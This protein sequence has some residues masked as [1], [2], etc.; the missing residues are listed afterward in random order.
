[1]VLNADLLEKEAATVTERA[2]VSD[3]RHESHARDLSAAQI[4]ATQS[5]PV[6][7]ARSFLLLELV[8]VHHQ[9][10]SIVVIDVMLGLGEALQ[11]LFGFLEAILAYEVPR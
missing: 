6:C 2:T 8:S 1:M 11:G 10:Y 9:R 5:V 7:G 3:M 4:S